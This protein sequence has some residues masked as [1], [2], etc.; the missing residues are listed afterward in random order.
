MEECG[1][2]AFRAAVDP[3]GFCTPSTRD[4]HPSCSSGETRPANDRFYEEYVPL[5][6]RLYDDHLRDLKREGLIE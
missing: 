1:S 3:S 5:A 6:D 4:A 2:Y